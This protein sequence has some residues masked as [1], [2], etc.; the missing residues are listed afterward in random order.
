MALKLSRVDRP[1]TPEKTLELG[2]H[3]LKAHIYKSV[4]RQLGYS[5][6]HAQ[7][8]WLAQ[9]SRSLNAALTSLHNVFTPNVKVRHCHVA[10][11][12]LHA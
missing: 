4:S 8:L 9:S 1:L 12:R 11:Q 6:K 3:V 2:H 10:A 7:A 5:G